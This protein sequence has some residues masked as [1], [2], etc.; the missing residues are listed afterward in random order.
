MN[1]YNQLW[2]YL[3]RRK[4]GFSTASRFLPLPSPVELRRSTYTGWTTSLLI[5]AR[6]SSLASWGTSTIR[7]PID[8]DMQSRIPMELLP[9][10]IQKGS[11]RPPTV[12]ITWFKKPVP[13]FSLRICL[14]PPINT[15]PGRRTSQAEKSKKRHKSSV[16]RGLILI[17]RRRQSV[18]VQAWMLLS[19]HASN[20]V[21]QVVASQ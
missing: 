5:N 19:C 20:L 17:I 18:D 12:N 1:P 15:A 9:I 10:G 16:S 14:N 4:G 11:L 3:E 21:C 8:K 7:H 13:S 6:P 2:L